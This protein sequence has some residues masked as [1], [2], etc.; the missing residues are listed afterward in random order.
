[1]KIVFMGTPDFAVPALRVLI[2]THEVKAVVT[3]P[4]KP[5]GR[6]AQLR[7]SPVKETALQAGI[8]VLQ[9]EKIRNDTFIEELKKLAPDVIIVAAYGKIIP[10]EIL[11]LPPYGCLNIHA[12]LLPKYRG[13]A[14]I[15][16]A[17]L[18]GEPETGITIM[19]MNEGLDTGDM[20]AVSRVKILPDETGG[21]LFDKMAEEGAR[22]L[23]DTLSK[24]TGGELEPVPQPEK[25]PTAYARM[26]RKEDGR[27]DWKNDAVCIERQIRG[28]SP[29]PGTFTAVHQKTCKIWKASLA[30]EETNSACCGIIQTAAE[31]EEPGTV[32]A[33]DKRGVFVQTG[34][35]ILCITELQLEGKRRMDAADFLRGHALEAGTV[36]GK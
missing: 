10:K 5:V 13:A 25:S 12:S 34:N 7:P 33:A 19:Q 18:D 9:P 6:K 29:W 21:S 26:I 4:D 17:I 31:T 27:I 30:G 1:M 23:A 8:P 14:P 32:L 24:L 3:Q 11:D 36:L 2:R 16:W 22:L 28:L 35:G 20:L 15:Q